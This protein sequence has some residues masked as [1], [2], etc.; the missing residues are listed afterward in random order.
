[1]SDDTQSAYRDRHFI[2]P[3]WHYMHTC[4]TGRMVQSEDI[5]PLPELKR[6]AFY[7]EVLRPQHMAHNFM[8]PLTTKPDFQLGFNICRSE[9]QGRLPEDGVRLF[10]NLYPH[11]RRSLLLGFRLDSYRAL[12][13][14]AFHVLDRLSVGIILL[15][16]RASVLF[17]NAAAAKLAQ[18]D[19]ALR[20]GSTGVTTASLSH[21]QRLDQFIRRGLAGTPVGVMSIPHPADG[22]LLTVLAISIRSRDF[23]RLSDLGF[24]NA[25]L[26][27]QISDPMHLP[28]VPVDRL[29]DAY[30]F[31]RAEARVA[32]AASTGRTV[33][34]IAAQL[35]LSPNT[36]KTHLRKVFAKCGVSRQIELTRLITSLALVK[37]DAKP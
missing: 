35:V 11:F 8:V 9:N 14:A 17:A 37:H 26:F 31:T 4:P 24:S 18:H 32:L 29:M 13:A 20:L 10:T 22:R 2:N 34:Q 23:D 16:G 19:G 25:A 7:N 21:S 12:H 28:A 36:I 15:D 33:P 1:M 30:G 5:V 27:L 6:S 3:W